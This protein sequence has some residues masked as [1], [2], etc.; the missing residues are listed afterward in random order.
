[1]DIDIIE[2]STFTKWFGGLSD[3]LALSVANVG[4]FVF[5]FYFNAARV[6]IVIDLH[7]GAR[8]FDIDDALFALASRQGKRRDGRR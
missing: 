8:R 4:L 2:T 7:F 5:R 1:V 3:E 6:E